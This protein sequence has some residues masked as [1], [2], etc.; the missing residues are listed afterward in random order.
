MY[1]ITHNA[2]S[3]FVPVVRPKSWKASSVVRSRER[4]DRIA[5]ARM[6][7]K[8]RGWPPRSGSRDWIAGPLPNWRRP[9]SH[10]QPSSAG[11]TRSIQLRLS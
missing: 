1:S 9:A 3:R 5:T 4:S 8:R 2:G 6:E 7:R 10:G 11:S